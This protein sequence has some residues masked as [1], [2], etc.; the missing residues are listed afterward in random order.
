[1]IVRDKDEGIHRCRI[2]VD[3]HPKSY[4]DI[5]C[6]ALQR[7]AIIAAREEEDE[8]EEAAVRCKGAREGAEA[9]AEVRFGRSAP[10]PPSPQ[11]RRWST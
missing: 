2:R 7:A 11:R 5:A 6:R 10:P 9:E 3:V 1:M 8:D 4:G